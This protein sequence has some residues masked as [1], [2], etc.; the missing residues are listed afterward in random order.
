MSSEEGFSVWGILELMGRTSFAGFISEQQ[1]GGETC[2]RI[3]VPKTSRHAEFTKFFG[4]K[5]LY[6]ITPTDEETARRYAEGLKA[7]PLPILQATSSDAIYI[8]NR[9]L[10]DSHNNDD[11]D[12][13]R[14]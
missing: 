11:A 4:G 14:Y 2:I 7:Q 5:A 8:D 9:F 6:S 12:D 1:I 10:T 13:T 3:D